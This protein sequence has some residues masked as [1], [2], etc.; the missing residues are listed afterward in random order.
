MARKF[1]LVKNDYPIKSR[2]PTKK[3]LLKGIE[4]TFYLIFPA[5]YIFL[6]M[7]KKL[8]VFPFMLLSR[9]KVSEVLNKHQT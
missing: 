9:V 8:T 5:K 2:R 7:S 6:P 1:F 4:E 3:C